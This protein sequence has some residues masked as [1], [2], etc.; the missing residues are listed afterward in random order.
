[1][2]Y[3]G[4]RLGLPLDMSVLCVFFYSAWVRRSSGCL[5]QN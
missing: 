4:A 5:M 3:D 1:M 2:K